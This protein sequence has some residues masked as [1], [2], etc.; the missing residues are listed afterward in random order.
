MKLESIKVNDKELTNEQIA[1]L[2]VNRPRN[3][4]Y[5]KG[6]ADDDEVIV[7]ASFDGLPIRPK[8][9]ANSVTLYFQFYKLVY[10]LTESAKFD[11]ALENV[12][13]PVK[14]LFK[15]K[16]V[17][18]YNRLILRGFAYEQHFIEAVYIRYYAENDDYENRLRTE[19]MK[20]KDENTIY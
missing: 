6:L 16:R 8:I 11:Q 7:S 9:R 2:F 19:V 10:S 14:L 20:E 5:V 4:Y 12:S 17:G 1:D 13:Y 18:G 15:V 3:G